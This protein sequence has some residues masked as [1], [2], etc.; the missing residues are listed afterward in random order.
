MRILHIDTG[1]EMRG[2]QYQALLLMQ[3]LRENGHVCELLAGEGSPLWR[4]A[5]SADFKVGAAS[6]SSIAKASRKADVVHAH[7]AGAHKLAALTTQRPMVVSRRVAFPIHRTLPSR[8]KYG[9]A[10]RFLAVSEFVAGQL[11]ESGVP[12]SKIDVVYDAVEPSQ[13]SEPWSPEFP[14]VALAS[15]DLQKGRTLV[16]SAARV[17]GVAVL[18]S[19]DL[20]RDLRRASVFVYISKSEGLGSAA[21]LAMQMG[22]PVIASA[23][24]GMRELFTDNVSG[25]YVNNDPVEIAK[26][27][28][29]VLGNPNLAATLITGAKQRVEEAFTVAR[30]LEKTVAAYTKALM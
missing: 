15:T 18:F 8:W 2:G 25:L 23:I 10:R 12:E 6:L 19:D 20:K 16:E 22:V 21:L 24:E 11:R 7:D 5:F 26:A 29:R 1:R 17:S 28:R 30:M 14:A 27:M 9:R 4:A 13:P 3:A